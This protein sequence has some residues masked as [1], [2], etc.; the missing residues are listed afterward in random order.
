MS[1]LEELKNKWTQRSTSVTAARSYDQTAFQKIIQSSVR[2]QQHISMQYF[3]AS[4]TLQIIV[5]ALLTHVAIKYR[6]DTAVLGVAFFCMLLYVPFT[7]MLL[8]KFK[9]LAVLKMAGK[10]AAGLPVY[11]YV[12]RQ[13]ALLVSFYRFKKAYELFLIPLS[14]AIMI[15]IFFRIYLPGGIA[16]YPVGAF[17]CFLFTL[18]ACAAAIIAENKKRFKRPI[19]QLEEIL[20][21]LKQD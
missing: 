7:I 19:S 6:A 2:K 9:R 8:R 10:H 18:G 11:E 3:W 5:Y 14:S 20:K 17:G 13:H 1:D 12:M 21:D 16:A 4:F 15:W